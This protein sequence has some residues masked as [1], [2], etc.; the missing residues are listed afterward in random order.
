MSS[1]A[2]KGKTALVSGASKGI[3]LACAQS[4]AADGANIV[5]TARRAGELETARDRLR[6]A[7]PDVRVEIC[8]ADACEEEQ[9]KRALALA[10]E[11]PGKLGMLV[12]VVGEPVFQ[13]ILERDLQSVRRELDINF[14]SAFLLIRHGAPLLGRGGSIACV[15]SI[16]SVKSSYGLGVYGAAKAALERFVRAAAFELGGAG[17]RINAVRPG[18]TLPPERAETPEFAKM[19]AASVAATPLG[20]YGQPEDVARVVRFLVGPEAGWVTG[21]AF[22]ADGGQEQD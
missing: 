5:I 15:S 20:R 12:S 7:N 19:V 11:I 9:V 22:S 4:L 8:Q 1:E 16:S 6:V 10:H 3:G 17:I 13:P 2:L 21:Q 14:I 18:M